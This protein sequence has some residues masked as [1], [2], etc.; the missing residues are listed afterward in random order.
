VIKYVGMEFWKYIFDKQAS[1]VKTNNQGDFMIID[2]DFKLV[3]GISCSDED[4]PL[5]K[6][7]V[8]NYEYFTQG[9]TKGAILNLGFHQSSKVQVNI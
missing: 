7:R 1:N 2:N 8:K 3:H 6:E 5:M 4:T 9:L